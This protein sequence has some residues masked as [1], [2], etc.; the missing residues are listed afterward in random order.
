MGFAVLVT[1]T[2]P[3]TSASTIERPRSV[4]HSV[5]T[6]VQ[7]RCLSSNFDVS[8]SNDEKLE[9]NA[10]M[11]GGAYDF[12]GATTSLTYELLSSSKKITIVRH[13]LSSW[14]DESRIQG[15]SDLSILTDTGVQQAE[16]CRK[17]LAD[18]SFDQCFSSPISRAKNLEPVD[19]KRIYPNEY[20]TWRE[21]PARFTVNG[22]YPI[23]NLWLT[24]K[25]A[26][27]E[28]LS[29]PVPFSRHKQ[30]RNLCDCLQQAGRSNASILEHDCPYVQ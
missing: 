20:T 11:T 7:I 14:N 8:L 5:K 3:F 28:I 2:L 23:R 27:R 13:G 25:E 26:W 24:G 15:S 4:H 1:T 16:K 18:I 19:A 22:I 9:N 30:W 29:A 10:S 21:D 12:K 17:A 6:R